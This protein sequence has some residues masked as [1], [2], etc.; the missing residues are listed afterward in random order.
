[1]IRRIV[2]G[3]ALSLRWLSLPVLLALAPVAGSATDPTTRSVPA[4]SLA[5]IVAEAPAG[6]QVE[7][8][9]PVL[10][11]KVTRVGDGDTIQVDVNPDGDIILTRAETPTPA[12]AP[13][14]APE[15]S[16]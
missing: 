3:F 13:E 8:P 14:V 15:S 2:P 12:P 11:G 10:P 1:M 6:T 16:V 7:S 5:A 9:N 4:A